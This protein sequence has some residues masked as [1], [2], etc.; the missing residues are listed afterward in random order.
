M[1][2]T[3]N[4]SDLDRIVFAF[5]IIERQTHDVA[6]K[7]SQT[8]AASQRITMTTNLIIRV[9]FISAIIL[10]PFLFFMIYTLT[11]DMSKIRNMMQGMDEHMYAMRENFD[12]VTLNV[13]QMQSDVG[14]MSQDVASLPAIDNSVSQMRQ[15]LSEMTQTMQNMDGNMGNM[16][17]SMETITQN[18]GSMNHVFSQMNQSVFFMQHN[19]DTL[20]R[21]ARMMPFNW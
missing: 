9:S 14:V 20:S 15:T 10:T 3:S 2:S 17:G 7:F 4:D 8:S 18:V 19:V 11:F 16:T 5:Q 1:N 12:R 21:P 13:D 6:G